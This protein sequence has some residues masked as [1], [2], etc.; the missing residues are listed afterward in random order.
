MAI[1]Y[2]SDVEVTDMEVS[3]APDTTGEQLPDG[4]DND[5]K[6]KLPDVNLDYVGMAEVWSTYYDTH[7]GIE[8]WGAKSFVDSVDM[9]RYH[10]NLA[11][12]HLDKVRQ[13]LASLNSETRVRAPVGQGKAVQTRTFTMFFSKLGVEAFNTQLTLFK[14]EGVSGER[15]K[16]QV[17]AELVDAAITLNGGEAAE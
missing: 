13:H 3:Y 12:T 7:R 1:N 14:V 10:L 4:M 15:S 9:V 2:G 11:G 16:E 5:T 8:G 6:I 17:I